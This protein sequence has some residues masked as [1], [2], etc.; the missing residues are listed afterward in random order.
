M[1]VLAHLTVCLQQS[2]DGERYVLSIKL[3]NVFLKTHWETSH[4]LMNSPERTLMFKHKILNQ[5]LQRTIQFASKLDLT[6]G[7][8]ALVSELDSDVKEL[9]ESSSSIGFE[10]ESFWRISNDFKK[11]FPK[12]EL[13][14]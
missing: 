7:D 13:F 5:I 12:K 1:R 4:P 14:P 3:I 9:E 11:K 6:E 8:Q 2:R 10:S